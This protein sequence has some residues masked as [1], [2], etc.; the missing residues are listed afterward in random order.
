MRGS[1]YLYR[2]PLILFR[3]G[4]PMYDK[5]RIVKKKYIVIVAVLLAVSLLALAGTL[6]YQSSAERTTEVTVPDNI[7][8]PK[9]QHISSSETIT[10]AQNLAGAEQTVQSGSEKAE[11]LTLYQGHSEDNT[12][13]EAVNMFPGDTLT[14]Y[15]CVRVSHSGGV[16]VYFHADIRSGYEKLAEVLNCR[17]ELLTDGSTLYDGLMRDMPDISSTVISDGKADSD[18]YYAVTAYLDTSVGNDYQNKELTADFRW[19][20]QADEEISSADSIESKTDSTESNA[21]SSTGAADSSSVSKAESTAVSKADSSDG[22]HG[23]NGGSLESPNTGSPAAVCM[24]VIVSAGLLLALLVLCG[25]CKKEGGC[26][27]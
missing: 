4:A 11:L 20:A 18:L 14:K 7:I 10:Q 15:Y 17:V 5:D 16:T 26:D 1:L 25:K 13:F 22:S 24:W 23:T 2:L 8:T 6:I 27:D 21:D 9:A 19:W 3:E 12:P